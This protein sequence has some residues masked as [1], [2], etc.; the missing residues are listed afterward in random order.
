ME[1]VRCFMCGSE[2][3]CHNEQIDPSCTDPSTCVSFLGGIE[4]FHGYRHFHKR[5]WEGDCWQKF[6][7]REEELRRAKEEEE[8]KKRGIVIG[9]HRSTYHPEVPVWSQGLRAG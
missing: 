1:M 7:Q 2:I 4:N 6:V 5:W 8:K 3:G 9:F